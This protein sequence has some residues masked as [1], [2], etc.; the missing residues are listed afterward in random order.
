MSVYKEK[1]KRENLVNTFSFLQNIDNSLFDCSPKLFW[2]YV[3]NPQ[4]ESKYKCD[5]VNVQI[6]WKQVTTSGEDVVAD[7]IKGMLCLCMLFM[8]VLNPLWCIIDIN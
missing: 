3:E 6:L 4:K 2:V 8:D 7:D 1:I 5:I